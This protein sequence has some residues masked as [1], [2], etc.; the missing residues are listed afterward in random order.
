MGFL[1]P[2]LPVVDFAEWNGVSRAERIRPMARHRAEA[3]FG[4]P[5]V[6]HL[7]YVVKILL[8]IVGGWLVV[9]AT[10]GV[11]GFTDVEQWWS[12]PVV[13]AKKSCATQCCSR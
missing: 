4:T 1:K 8:Y 5:V 11:D 10:A 6:L 13:F 12:E 2:H 9:L 3:G 7:F